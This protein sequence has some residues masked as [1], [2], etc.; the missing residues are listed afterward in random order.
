MKISHKDISDCGGFFERP[1][2][3][4]GIF[5]EPLRCKRKSKSEKIIELRR[6][7][8]KFCNVFVFSKDKNHEGLDREE[9]SLSR[10]R[11]GTII[12]ITQKALSFFSKYSTK[13]STGYFRLRI[14]WNSK[15]GSP[16]IIT[17]SRPLDWFWNSSFA[18]I[19][20]I[21]FR[22]NE[23]RTLSEEISKFVFENPKKIATIETV[24][25]LSAVPAETNV[26][27]SH[28]ERRKSRLLEGK[29]WEDYII[30]GVPEGM[31]V[32]H[33]K[34]EKNRKGGSIEDFS[35]FVKLETRI[36]GWWI[37]IIV[38]LLTLIFNIL[39][40]KFVSIASYIFIGLCNIFSI[41]INIVIFLANCFNKL[42]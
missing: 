9:I 11:D 10:C 13:P 37:L 18:Q 17:K 3:A 7:N 12:E 31:V 25:F 6:K 22:L 23:I 15:K 34:K 8:K 26:V 5:N 42:F 4:Q 35:A 16:F 20:Y 30:G 41:L 38:I 24:A 19:N 21:D 32:H 27:N 40:D 14:Q 39:A 36:T 33:W 1:K 28:E 29:I 2:I